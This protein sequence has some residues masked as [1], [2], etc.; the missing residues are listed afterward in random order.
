MKTIPRFCTKCKKV[1]QARWD[2]CPLCDM[3]LGLDKSMGIFLSGPPTH[4]STIMTLPQDSVLGDRFKIKQ[5]LGTGRLGAVYLAEDLLAI[6]DVALKIVDIGPSSERIAALQLLREMMVQN[7]LSDFTHVIRIF[8]FHFVQWGG[9]GLLVLPMEYGEGG[10]F[11]KWLIEH[12]DDLKARR[13]I[14]LEFFKQACYGVDSA[15]RQNIIHLDLKPENFIFL[16]EVLKVSDFGTANFVRRLRELNKHLPEIAIEELGTLFY[17]SPEH[18]IV[19]SLQEL[20]E[21]ADIYSLGIVL[22]ELLHPTC[23]PPFD[24]FGNLQL[25]EALRAIADF[26]EKFTEIIARCLSK[27]P[28]GRYRN[29]AE[30]IEALEEGSDTQNASF[31][32]NKESNGNSSMNVDRDLNEAL[33]C[34]SNKAFDQASRFIDQVIKAQPDNIRANSLREEINLRFDQAGQ[35][36]EN[37]AGNL[38]GGDLRELSTMLQEAMSIYPNHPS[39]HPVQAKLAERCRQYRKAMEEALEAMRESD[40]ES[41]LDS[42]QQ[43]E[44]IHSGIHQTRNLISHL[45]NLTAARTNRDLA[46]TQGDFDKAKK[47]HR[48]VE[49]QVNLIKERIPA[50][51]ETRTL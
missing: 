35:L 28:S 39:G 47:L 14:G 10:S 17:R 21:R 1:V 9:T 7:Q 22:L 26:G 5:P 32:K 46:F 49:L 24:K 37:I 16:D 48:L 3:A 23:R 19:S 31:M 6:R 11:R 25:T 27:D 34:F 13:S 20:D 2:R 50:L 38:D 30:L 45:S 36:Y 41:A 43:A 44:L 33:V 42:L 18:L 12:M 15:H 4:G 40:W 51:K 29:T 8:D